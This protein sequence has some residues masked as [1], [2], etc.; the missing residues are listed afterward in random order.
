MKQGTGR[1]GHI[2]YNGPLYFF[3][4]QLHRTL[5]ATGGRDK[6]KKHTAEEEMQ[7]LGTPNTRRGPTHAA[8]L[9][10]MWCEKGLTDVCRGAEAENDW[11]I[12][13]VVRC[14]EQWSTPIA[15]VIKRTGAHTKMRFLRISSLITRQLS[16]WMHKLLQPKPLFKSLFGQLQGTEIAHCSPPDRHAPKTDTRPQ[17]VACSPTKNVVFACT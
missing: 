8:M 1:G 7:F 13:F 11:P 12:W 4:S 5:Y 6:T 3:V 16:A 2:A 17:F 9:Y 10:S 15:H 14:T